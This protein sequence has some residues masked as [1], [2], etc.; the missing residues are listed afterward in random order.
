M[1]GKE[2]INELNKTLGF[3]MKEAVL[4]GV[5][6]N[7]HDWHE[8]VYG[9]QDKIANLILNFLDDNQEIKNMVFSILLKQ[10]IEGL[11]NIMGD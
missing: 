6:P 10:G 2:A 4:I 5:E 11:T 7:G 3:N 1:D 8:T 9:Q